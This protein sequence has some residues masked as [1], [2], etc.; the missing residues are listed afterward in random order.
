[1]IGIYDY[2]VI[3]TYLSAISA[4][5]GIM[6]T[7]KDTG[8]PYLGI[9]FL[10]ICGL[11]DSF[12][13]KVARS[14]KDRTGK[15]KDFGVQIDSLSDVIAFGVLPACIGMALYKQDLAF[16]GK[17]V[18]AHVP[19]FIVALISAL[20][21]LCALIRLAYFN[22]TVEET[23]NES[24]GEGKFY[25]GLPVTSAAL[26]FPTFILVR[27]FLCLNLSFVYYILL[28]IVALLFV[29]KFKLKKPSNG[30]VYFMILIG[31]I[32]FAIVLAIRLWLKR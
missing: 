29:I 32:E 21:V 7:L 30:K 18:L 5:I 3:L 13:G 25:F 24:L 28:I 27:H 19:Y 16:G 10:M 4:C 26:I 1:M 17:S 15:E 9:L 6:T 23:Q 22:I 12:D 14:K 8:H 11:C 31:A 20:Y 2:T